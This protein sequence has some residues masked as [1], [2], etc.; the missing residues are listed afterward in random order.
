[1]T[2]HRQDSQAKAWLLSLHSPQLHIR[3]GI[4]HFKHWI[5]GHGHSRSP[6]FQICPAFT[7]FFFNL[8]Y[9]GIAD[10]QCQL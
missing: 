4:F 2:A 7:F 10:L 6:Y 5:E 1:M 9:W 3:K 8:L